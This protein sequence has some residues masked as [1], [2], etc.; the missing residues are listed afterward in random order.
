MQLPVDPPAPK[1]PLDVLVVV[2]F[3]VPAGADWVPE[4]NVSVTVAVQVVCGPFAVYG[5]GTQV[6][7]V[8]VERPT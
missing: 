4:T 7:L 2:K 5:L 6:R 3:T 8:L 1:L